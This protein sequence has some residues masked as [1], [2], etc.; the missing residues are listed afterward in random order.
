MKQTIAQLRYTLRRIHTVG[1]ESLESLL[2]ALRLIETW[3][4]GPFPA[5]AVQGALEKITVTC[6]ADADRLLGCMQALDT[7][8]K[9][10]AHDGHHEPEQDL[11]H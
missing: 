2:T 7:L 4:G 3:E 10:E 6:A 8:M 11:P 9:E 5:R 1:R